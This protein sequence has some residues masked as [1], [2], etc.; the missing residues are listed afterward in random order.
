M[1]KVYI[2]GPYTKGDVA[3]NVK[4]AMDVTNI[5]I[6]KG[7]APYCPHLSHF[8]HMASP[9][10]YETWTNLDNEYVKVCDCLLRLTGVSSGA[11]A[12]V[13]LAKSLGL[14]IFY[15]IE[16]LLCWYND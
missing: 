9:Q 15:S 6:Q 13:L 4:N 3:I 10:P 11:D 5:L 1:T 2:A 12:E 14:P 16:E 7:F 8:L